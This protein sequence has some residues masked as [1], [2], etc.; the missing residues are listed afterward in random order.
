MILVFDLTVQEAWPFS[1]FEREWKIFDILILW[2]LFSEYHSRKKEVPT[3]RKNRSGTNKKWKIWVL[4][5]FPN[6]P[7]GPDRALWCCYYYTRFL[8]WFI[9]SFSVFFFVNSILNASI[10]YKT[11]EGI[12]SLWV[13]L[14]HYSELSSTSMIFNCLRI[15]SQAFF[16]SGTF[17][18]L[19]SRDC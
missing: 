8:I 11:T 17:H 12:G 13:T 7:R 10:R 18:E 19:L 6:Y 3:N 15:R 9:L 1:I 14:F 16:L 2:V 4:I 5:S